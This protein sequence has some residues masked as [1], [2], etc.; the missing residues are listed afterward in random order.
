MGL[1]LLSLL[2]S[3]RLAVLDLSRITK[4]DRFLR[5]TP[6][7]PVSPPCSLTLPGYVCLRGEFSLN[8]MKLVID[9]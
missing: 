6:L 7:K 3:H 4:S 1:T 9:G 2:Y 8:Y 5:L